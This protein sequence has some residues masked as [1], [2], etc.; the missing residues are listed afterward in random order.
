MARA[1]NGR[2]RRGLPMSTDI[3]VTSLVD[4]AFTLLVIFIITAPILQAGIELQLPRAEAAPITATEGVVVSVNREGMIFV[5]EVPARTV[6]EFQEVYPMV[7][8]ELNARTAYVRADRDVS[9]G[10]V[11]QVIGA[12]K[13]MDVAEVSLIAEPEPER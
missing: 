12:M 13:E 2:G 8:A 11:L 4:V 3:N 6:E 1:T 9:Y 10:R 7:V 5:G